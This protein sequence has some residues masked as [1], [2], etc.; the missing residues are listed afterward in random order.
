MKIITGH[1]GFIGSHFA[2]RHPKYIGLEHYNAVALIE[3]FNKWED[4]EEIIHLGAIS[5][6][7]E[8]NL[9]KLHHFNVNITLMLFLKAIEYQIP[10][11]YASSASVYGNSTDGSMNPL[12][13]Y[14]L[15]KTQIDYWVQDNIDKF[16]SIQGFRFFNVYGQG[17]ER[18]ENQQSPVSKFIQQAKEDGVIKIFEGSDKMMR[19]FVWVDDVIDVMED[20]GAPSG[21]YDIGSGYTISFKEVAEIIAKKYGAEIKEIPFPKHLHG[22]YQYETRSAGNWVGKNF[23]TVEDYINRLFELDT[24]HNQNES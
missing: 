2:R 22:K 9:N 8:T 14:A 10:V 6:T 19:D 17:E 16:K 12:N 21:I 20:N 4:I 24:N 13:Y 11:K 15:T 18:K 7:T 1:D 3:N 23:M 5:S